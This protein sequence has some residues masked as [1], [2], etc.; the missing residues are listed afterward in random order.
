MPSKNIRKEHLLLQGLRDPLINFDKSA[1]MQILMKVSGTFV[2][3][4]GI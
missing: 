2:W 1:K 4:K 3:K